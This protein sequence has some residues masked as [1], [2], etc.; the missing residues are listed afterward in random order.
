[1][2]KRQGFWC[3]SNPPAGSQYN[4]PSGVTLPVGLLGTNW[5]SVGPSTIFHAFHGDRWA[6][7]KF[8]VDAADADTGVVSWSFGGFQDA[9][10]WG[11]GD[12][13]MM[14]GMLSFLDDYDEWFLDESVT[15][16]ALYV[17]F[18]D[19]G[20]APDASTAF[21][22]TRVDSLLRLQGSAAAPVDGVTISG[23]TLSHTAPTF[24]K[25]F[26]SASGGDWSVRLDAALLLNGTT[27]AVVE[28]CSFYG[29]GGNAVMLF[30][31]NRGARIEGNAFRFVGDSAIVALGVVNGID[32]RNQ[33]VPVGTVVDG[34]QA[35]ELGVY[36][37][38]SGFYYHAQSIAAT[39]TR[40]VFFNIPRAG[41]NIND[42]FGGGHLVDQNCA[43]NTVRETVSP[44]EAAAT[45]LTPTEP[46][47]SPPAFAV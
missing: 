43:F 9:R 24:M 6:D 37:K 13:F 31:F 10:G 25:P 16:P 20:P 4:V 28:G 26:A 5:S 19:T 33:D 8:Q 45:D 18:N 21:V 39:V 3:S 38:Q 23:L 2:Y 46:P 42:G 35:A 27:S 47:P 30:A 12:T 40:N 11:S 44:L 36:T 14:E 17:M 22:A 1:V 41:I 29:L 34:N 32:G 7:W 15:P